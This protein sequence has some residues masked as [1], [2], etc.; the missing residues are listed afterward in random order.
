M[1]QEVIKYDYNPYRDPNRLGN[2][3]STNKF[4]KKIFRQ[5]L[6]DQDY[7]GAAIYA[8]QYRPKDNKERIALETYTNG[9]R[10]Y[11]ARLTK[12]TE[13]LNDSQREAVNFKFALDN[14]LALPGEH[15]N[16][17]GSVSRNRYTEQ[18]R[19]FIDSIG[20]S[21]DGSTK[22]DKLSIRFLNDK[23]GNWFT[24]LVGIDNNEDVI[25]SFISNLNDSNL[26]YNINKANMQ[27]EF[28][29]MGITLISSNQGYEIQFDKSNPRILD[30]F[31]AYNNSGLD[32]EK[33]SIAG[34]DD[35]GKYIG[36]SFS[37]QSHGDVIMPFNQSDNKYNITQLLNFIDSTNS[38]STIA[39]HNI[40][41][42]NMARSM[43]ISAHYNSQAD[44]VAW[45]D[46]ADGL[47][48]DKQ[49]DDIK[50]HI[51]E[52]MHGLLMSAFTQNEM[53]FSD[54][55]NDVLHYAENADR[56][57]LKDLYNIASKVKDGVLIR[58]AKVGDR[59]GTY[60]EIK[61]EANPD[62]SKS[63]YLLPGVK[64]ERNPN[65]QTI[66][67]FIPDLEN[68]SDM[69]ALYADPNSRAMIELTDMKDYGYETN[70]SYK[71]HRG[72]Q[73]DATIKYNPANDTF[74]QYNYKTGVTEENINP[75]EAQNRLAKHYTYNDLTNRLMSSIRDYDGN[76]NPNNLNKAMELWS[77]GVNNWINEY[78]PLL[79]EQGKNDLGN[80]LLQDML[81][82]IQISNTL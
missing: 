23:N 54:T 4:D 74:T 15:K 49:Y 28:E 16:A 64:M 57:K 56:D 9:L 36:D 47:I 65:K 38:N 44:A 1:A 14:N 12:M 69:Q 10:K 78:Y 50:K 63:K 80:A 53:Y 6:S 20:S 13:G 24:R 58:A 77:V 37:R 62:D 42:G 2:Y 71:D 5:L 25:Q 79:D 60:V 17:D 18:Y 55:E 43:I 51:E 41:N 39:E 33:T 52:G 27:T 35:K 3:K 82:E 48:S 81:R 46:R 76:I 59:Y 45:Q 30:I 7:E 61:P 75:L 21:P 72:V 34:I 11:G 26:G 40:K 66:K 32:K 70:V 22:S 67:L 8:E 68:G 73:Q 29:N 19:K 31:R